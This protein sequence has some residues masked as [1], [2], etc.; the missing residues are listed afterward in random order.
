M[1]SG[2]PVP[3]SGS[4]HVLYIPLISKHILAYIGVLLYPSYGLW[5]IRFDFIPN[6]ILCDIV[7]IPETK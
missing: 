6:C 4:A 2:P 1:G 7:T 3:L 5:N